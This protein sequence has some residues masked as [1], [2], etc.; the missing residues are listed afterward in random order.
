MSPEEGPLQAQFTDPCLH[1]PRGSFPPL[2][3]SLHTPCQASQPPSRPEPIPE[4]GHPP[5]SCSHSTTGEILV[6]GAPHGLLVL[7]EIPENGRFIWVIVTKHLIRTTTIIIIIASIIHI[8][9]IYHTPGSLLNTL[10]VLDSHLILRTTPRGGC[11]PHLMD[12]E[13]EKL[14]V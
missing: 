7:P 3:H 14:R 6:P 11:C 10:R 12:E 1:C 13:I 2:P 8:S 5:R 4:A 9:N